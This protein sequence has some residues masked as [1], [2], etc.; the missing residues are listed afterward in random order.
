[1]SM[2][3]SSNVSIVQNMVIWQEIAL[4]KQF[5]SNAEAKIISKKTAPAKRQCAAI[6]RAT[7]PLLLGV[8][9]P[10]SES[11]EPQGKRNCHHQRVM[12]FNKTI[13]S[14]LHN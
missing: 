9:P 7:M 8:V 11:I 14:Q 6:A 1:M 13:F 4:E 5:V 10:N 3:K 12:I 2:S